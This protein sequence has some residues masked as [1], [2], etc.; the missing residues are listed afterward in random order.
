M[1]RSVAISRRFSSIFEKQEGLKNARP[2]L[3]P[4]HY[5]SK[6]RQVLSEHFPGVE[7]A[8]DIRSLQSL[9][10]VRRRGEEGI[11]RERGWTEPPAAEEK[12][13]KLSL[14]L[15]HLSLLLLLFPLENPNSFP[16]GID[17]VVAGFP[18]VDVSR[19]G[20]RAGLDGRASGLVRRFFS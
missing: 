5:N 10:E 12:K 20:L 17:L 11:G 2:F 8:H 14:T 15:P 7:L 4:F 13:K 1:P 9:P 18:C 19:A 3:I 6:K 16:K